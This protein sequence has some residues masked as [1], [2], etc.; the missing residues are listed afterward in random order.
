MAELNWSDAQWQKVKDSVTEAFGKGEC[1]V[2]RFL[3]MLRAASR[4]R[5]DSAQ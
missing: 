1:I 5:R 3:P 2:E 4:R